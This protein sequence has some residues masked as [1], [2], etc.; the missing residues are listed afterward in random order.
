M[1]EFKGPKQLNHRRAVELMFRAAA[2]ELAQRS[3][4][5]Y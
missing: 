2:R 4:N 1:A 5:T 3:P